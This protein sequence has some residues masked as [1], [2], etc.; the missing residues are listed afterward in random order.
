M[1]TKAKEFSS[2]LIT[3]ALS[4]AIAIA[5]PN[6]VSAATK[7]KVGRSASGT[8]FELPVYVAM[9]KGF[10]KRE[11]L[12]AVFVPL[13]RKALVTAGIAG[14]IDFSPASRGGAQA[15]LKGAELRFVVGQSSQAQWTI[16]VSPFVVR[17]DDLKGKT[18]GFGRPNTAGFEEG[19]IA[20]KRVFNFRVGRDYK[21]RSFPSASARIAAL[22]NGEIHGA[23]LSIANAAKAGVTGFPNFLPSGQGASELNGAYWVRRAYLGKNP[24]AVAGF[25]RAITTAINFI[26][27][28]HE[29][30]ADVIQKYLGIKKRT[31]ANHYWWA[32]QNLY[33]P[34]IRKDLL[35]ELFEERRS[36]MVRKGLWPKTKPIPNVDRFVARKLLT[37]TLKD[38]RYHMSD[39]ANPK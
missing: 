12:D 20:L 39:A 19:K 23:V 28:N 33:S 36:R 8:I 13:T 18:V 24:S 17:G 7:I 1:T 5:T 11:G 9:E 16:S 27:L 14:A 22:Q 29:S 21:L 31:E 2:A 6:S 30:T 4:A 10:F 32:I 38:M 15:A 34:V 3:V 26:S 37:A 25:I 35:A